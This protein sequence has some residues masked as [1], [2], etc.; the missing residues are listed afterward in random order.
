MAVIC[1]WCC[2]LRARSNARFVSHFKCN[3]QRSAG[4][5]P[6]FEGR[7]SV[8]DPH[9]QGH[10]QSE[11]LGSWVASGSGLPIAPRRSLDA[12]ACAS[13]AR[14]EASSAESLPARR[15]SLPATATRFSSSS[16]AMAAWAVATPPLTGPS[17]AP[18][19]LPGAPLRLPAELSLLLP[20]LPP[21]AELP[22]SARP[23]LLPSPPALPSSPFL[24]PPASSAPPPPPPLLPP[25]PSCSKWAA[26]ERRAEPRFDPGER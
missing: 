17:P 5:L 26:A 22:P 24:P 16:R 25:P 20:G 11:S 18:P 4:V 13:A 9:E 2:E 8:R 23:G 7:G 6:G 15:N 19:P 10:A 1:L 3:T 21:S 14:A 12:R